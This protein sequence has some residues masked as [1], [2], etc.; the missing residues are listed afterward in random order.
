MPLTFN[1]FAHSSPVV[2]SSEIETSLDV[3]FFEI[4]D[5]STALGMTNV[6]SAS[7]KTPRL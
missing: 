6:V 4:R 1:A 3:S 5:S 2:M 7:V